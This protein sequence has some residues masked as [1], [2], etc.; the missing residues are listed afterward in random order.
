MF[1]FVCNVLNEYP[2]SYPCR[3]SYEHVKSAK[4][5]KIDRCQ[6]SRS[7]VKWSWYSLCFTIPSFDYSFAIKNAQ[8]RFVFNKKRNV[9]VFFYP[10]EMYMFV[11]RK[12]YRRHLCYCSN[13]Q[14]KPIHMYSIWQIAF[15][16]IHQSNCNMLSWFTGTCRTS[17]WVCLIAR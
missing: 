17:W 16:N 12:G 7:F 15:L 3:R 1:A 2:R 9:Y 10:K 4:C 6:I 14:K 13:F 5:I 11:V 8:K